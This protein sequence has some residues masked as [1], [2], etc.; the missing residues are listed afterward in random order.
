[1]SNEKL[2]EMVLANNQILAALI[3]AVRKKDA[4]DL[5]LFNELIETTRQN[6]KA[7]GTGKNDTFNEVIETAKSACLI[8][9]QQPKVRR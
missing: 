8:L 1:M 2:Q 5:T 9:D 7:D 3:A 6:H 4:L